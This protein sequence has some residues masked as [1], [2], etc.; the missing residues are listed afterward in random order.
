MLP[1]MEGRRKIVVHTGKQAFAY[2]FDRVT[3]SRSGRFLET[4]V[5]QTDVPGEWTSPTQP[6]PSKPP[7]FDMQGLKESDLI[8]FTPEFRRQAI[9][10]LKNSRI[11]L[12]TDLHSGLRW[13]MRPMVP[14][15]QSSF[16][17]QEAAQIGGAALPIRK[18]GLCT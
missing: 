2:V 13:P 10:A 1:S 15:E 12:W 18:R 5:T 16:R 7:G 4:P 17:V 6:I 11:A 14:G 9:E 8:D 3:G